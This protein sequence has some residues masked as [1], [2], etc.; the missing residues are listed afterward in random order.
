MRW[1]D[2][3]FIQHCALCQDGGD[4]WVCQEEDCERAICSECI[5]VPADEMD[6]VRQPNVKFT[7]VP[8]HWIKCRNENLIYY[9]SASSV[10]LCVFVLKWNAGFHHQWRTSSE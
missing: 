3:Y 10:H 1:N 4:L 2:G 9:V 6:K 5:E 8:C 7:C